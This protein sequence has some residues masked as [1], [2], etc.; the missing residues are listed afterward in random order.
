M[1][2][3]ALQL[4][5]R[6]R[7]LGGGVDRLTR[8]YGRRAG[9]HPRLFLAACLVGAAAIG[10]ACTLRPLLALMACAVLALIACVWRWPAL[11]AY[12]LIAITP[13]TAG[14]ERG[15]I[16]VLRPNEAL[17]FLL[18][19]ALA[20]RALVRWRTGQLP[21]IRLNRIELGIV[22]MAV[23]NSIV[24]LLWLRVRGKEIAGDDLQYAIV[25]WKY[26]MLY[27][28]VRFSVR[29]DREV[30]RCLWLSMGA[31]CIVALIA[32]LQSLNLFGVPGLLA[33]YYAPFGDTGALSIARGS[34]TLSLA[35]ATGDLMIYNLAIA[36][37][38][39]F[40]GVGRRAVLAVAI[41]LFMLGTLSAGETSTVIGLLVAVVG[42]AAVAGSAWILAYFLPAAAAAS[43]VM[44][45]VVSK[46]LSGFQSAYGL[47]VSWIGRLHNLQTY[48]LPPLFSDW[49]F[50]LGVRPAARVTVASQITGYVWIESGYIWLLWG[51]GIP[52]LASFVFFVYASLRASWTA[53]RRAVDATSIAG[54][55]AFV[56]VI[57]MTT[58]MVFD[59]HLTYRGAGDAMFFL[60]AL[61][62]AGTGSGNSRTARPHVPA[63][64]R[65]QSE[66]EA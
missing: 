32:I 21:R 35:A 61:V 22:L 53:A 9:R 8:R 24:P 49:N 4:G 41:A 7:R 13:L 17:A 31:A 50:L 62:V 65:P 45:P 47:P 59:P 20:S 11:A 48:F 40:K 36:C 19:L 3:A 26:L 60:L 42:M 56:A 16:P 66:G 64:S 12:L 33:T 2:E 25:L 63:G 5:R 54:F 34:S 38:M 44:R 55:A 10:G 14:V 6:P 27:A 29:N 52:L 18:A 23:T 39:W 51:G 37:G 58:L 46:R 1:A 57:V 43:V 30:W 15:V 28:I